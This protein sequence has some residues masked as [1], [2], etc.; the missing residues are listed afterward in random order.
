MT[1]E[2]KNLEDLAGALVLEVVI[3]R[4]DFGHGTLGFRAV[5]LWPAWTHRG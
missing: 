4:P 3:V 5:V 1:R 2:N